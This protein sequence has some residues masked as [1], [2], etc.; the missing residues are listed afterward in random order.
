MKV[1]VGRALDTQT[2]VFAEDM[3]YV[4]FSPYWNVPRSIALN[5]CCPSCAGCR[6]SSG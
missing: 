6:L 1:I 5:D 3:R 2:P 4:E